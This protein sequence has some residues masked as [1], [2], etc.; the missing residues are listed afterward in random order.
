MIY[1]LEFLISFILVLGYYYFFIIRRSKKYN[2]SFLPTEA[3][4]LV[5]ISKLDIKKI[6]YKRLLWHIAI[7][8]SLGISSILLATNIIDKYLLKIVFALG[9][10][11]IY[12]IITNYIL[13]KIYKKKGW[14]KK[15]V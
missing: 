15:N 5:K 10:V 3:S 13:S 8:N 12:I 6:G 4:L 9:L 1:I 14:T 2:E 7:T 11:I